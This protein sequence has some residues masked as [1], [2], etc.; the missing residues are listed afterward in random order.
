[1]K[2]KTLVFILSQEE[3]TDGGTIT[4]FDFVGDMK[5]KDNM[6]AY[7]LEQVLREKRS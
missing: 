2:D 1:M 7:F 6:S 4:S 5:L 3:G